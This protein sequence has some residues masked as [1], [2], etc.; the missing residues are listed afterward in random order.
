MLLYLTN[1]PLLGHF[2]LLEGNCKYKIYSLLMDYTCVF[3]YYL[4][5][6]GRDPARDVVIVDQEADLIAAIAGMTG[7]DF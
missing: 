2:I 4:G 7:K 5:G 6:Q 3:Y 1:H